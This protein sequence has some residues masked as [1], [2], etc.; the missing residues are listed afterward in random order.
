MGTEI[1]RAGLVFHPACH[2]ER[3]HYKY[4]ANGESIKMSETERKEDRS[5]NESGTRKDK[6]QK[7]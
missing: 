6:R 3:R 7:G 5:G 4:T 2:T 1:Q